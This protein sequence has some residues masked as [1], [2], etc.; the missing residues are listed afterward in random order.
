MIF[1]LPLSKKKECVKLQINYQQQITTELML[2][3]ER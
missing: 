1:Q 2:E 3:I